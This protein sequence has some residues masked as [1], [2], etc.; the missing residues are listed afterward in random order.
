MPAASRWSGVGCHP[1]GN[2]E[3]PEAQDHHPAQRRG[4]RTDPR[5]HPRILGR[6]FISFGP[7]DSIIDHIRTSGGRLGGGRPE[8]VLK[9]LV[10]KIIP[11]DQPLIS[12]TSKTPPV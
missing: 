10:R 3:F 7:I 5:P 4:L 9:G 2:P 8:N 12:I 1:A 6:Q 11:K